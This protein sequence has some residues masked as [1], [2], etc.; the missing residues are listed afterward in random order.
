MSAT[1][2]DR[3]HDESMTLA[4]V[5]SLRIGKKHLQE[6]KECVEHKGGTSILRN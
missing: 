4:S 3:T 6:E 2:V 5:P 1:S